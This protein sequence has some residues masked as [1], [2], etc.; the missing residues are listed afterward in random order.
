M[1]AHNLLRRLSNG[2]ARFSFRSCKEAI[3]AHRPPNYLSHQ[4]DNSLG[5]VCDPAAW[6]VAGH[7]ILNCFCGAHSLRVDL[8]GWITIH[9]QSLLLQHFVMD[10]AD[11]VIECSEATIYDCEFGK[12]IPHQS[13]GGKAGMKLHFT[14]KASRL[15]YQKG[16]K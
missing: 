2:Q 14:S 4:N 12:R 10:D 11:C 3:P 1:V 15:D 16:Y 7:V 8:N 5:G 13:D 6:C 9:P